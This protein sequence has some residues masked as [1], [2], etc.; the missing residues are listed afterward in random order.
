M[1][2][3]RVESPVLLAITLLVALFT[4]LPMLVSIAAGLVNN[5]A[6]GLASGLTT[7]W[8]QEVWVL[9]GATAWR[10]VLLAMVCALLAR[11]SQMTAFTPKRRSS[12]VRIVVLAL[13][14]TLVCA[15]ARVG[16]A[17]AR[18]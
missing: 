10:S 5:Y 13:M 15:R 12:T 8:L 17:N 4:L 7:R 11:G 16:N 14:V 18:R 1:R 3:V 9:Y 2:Q 6:V